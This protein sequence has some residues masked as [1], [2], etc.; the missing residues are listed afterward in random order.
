MTSAGIL[1][2]T[3]V[4]LL[5][6]R[7]LR[8]KHWLRRKRKLRKTQFAVRSVSRRDHILI[9]LLHGALNRAGSDAAVHMRIFSY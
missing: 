2:G 6:D 4:D 1:L 8:R 9:D 3:A 5:R 7:I